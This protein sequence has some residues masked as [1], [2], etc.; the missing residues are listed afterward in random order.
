MVLSSSIALA[1]RQRFIRST[2]LTSSRNDIT[3]ALTHE[4]DPFMYQQPGFEYEDPFMTPLQRTHNSPLLFDAPSFFDPTAALELHPGTAQILDDMR[5]LLRTVLSLPETPT[6]E[7]LKTAHATATLIYQRIDEMPKDIL[8]DD[9][10]AVLEY[11]TPPSTVEE[12]TNEKDHKQ[13]RPSPPASKNNGSAHGREDDKREGSSSKS[14]SSSPTALPQTPDLA[15]RCVRRVALIY[16]RAILT[17]T[18]TS[19]V[20]DV[21]EFLDIWSSM[22]QNTMA[23][24][25]KIIGIFM[26][27]LVAIVPSC[28]EAPKVRF[29][30]TLLTNGF[31][32][33]AVENWHVAL[34][35]AETALRLQ[36]WLRGGIRSLAK[37]HG[38]GGFAGK[39]LRYG[40]KQP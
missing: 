16:C 40:E 3:L 14:D 38:K 23:S 36:K 9:N 32:A 28:D 34:E 21:H 19:R 39:A 12:Q 2:M 20:C 7:E 24:W 18:P 15:Y 6:I 11:P 27:A 17:R 35:A 33:T 30:E 1:P 29:V 26:W 31:M 5:T 13:K 10:K 22:W 8:V 4:I 37:Q 25:N